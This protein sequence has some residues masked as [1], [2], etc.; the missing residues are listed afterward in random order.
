MAKSWQNLGKLP[1]F[2][3]KFT[4]SLSIHLPF[5]GYLPSFSS[6]NGLNAVRI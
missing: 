2:I 4:E 3:L 6:P 1:K 5:L